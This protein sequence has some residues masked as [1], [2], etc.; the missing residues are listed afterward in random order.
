MIYTT[1]LDTISIIE[2]MTN[3]LLNTALIDN[4]IGNIAVNPKTNN[5]YITL[6]VDNYVMVLNQKG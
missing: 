5:I 4:L 1:N 3:K 2:G 6:P